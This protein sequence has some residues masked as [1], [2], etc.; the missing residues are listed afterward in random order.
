MLAQPFTL[1]HVGYML[2]GVLWTLA[3]S[4]LAFVFGGI[5][6]FGVMLLRI[7]RFRAVRIAS[8]VVVQIVQG[9]PLLVILF[10]VYFGL[11]IF[12]FQV[13]PII[14]AGVAM[15]IY[16]AAFLAEIWRGCVEAVPRTQFEAAECLALTRWEALRKVILPQAFRLA[17]PPTVGFMVQVVKSTSL[18]SVVGFVEL[19][20]AAQIINNS[21]FQSFLVFGIAGAFYFAICWPLSA[22]SRTLERKLHV[23]RH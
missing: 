4:A 5:A 9:I 22:W 1:A 13:A 17:I 2:N 21:T 7:S 15:M 23:G 20:R 6:G 8:L 3:L 12:G 18:A 14:A 19:T 10:A 11:G 16:S